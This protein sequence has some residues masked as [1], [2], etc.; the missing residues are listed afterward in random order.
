M[1]VDEVRGKTTERSGECLQ[2]GQCCRRLGWLL[3]YA[4]EDTLE[5]I[6]ARDSEIQIVPDDDVMDYYWISMPY[7]CQHLVELEDGRFS[8]DMHDH[9]PSICKR[10]PEP[11]DELKPGC[12]YHFDQ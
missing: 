10:Y 4:E 7:P 9:K 11:T 3:I 12:G 6:R 1:A 5:W 2:C 8:C